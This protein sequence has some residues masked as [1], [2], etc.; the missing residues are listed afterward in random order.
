MTAI[1]ID[2]NLALALVVPLPYSNTVQQLVEKWHQQ[3]PCVSLCQ[4]CG[5]TSSSPACAR[6][7]L[8][9]CS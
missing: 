8:L 4:H 6:R 7:L 1:V 5:D 9:A 2:A 3:A